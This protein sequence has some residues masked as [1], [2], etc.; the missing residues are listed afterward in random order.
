MII[1]ISANPAI[2]R[3]LQI[4]ELR[5]GEVNRALTVRPAPGGK[6]AHVAMAARALGTE[7]LWVGFLGGETGI[8]CARGLAALGIAVE[9]VHTRSPTRVNQEILDADGRITEILEPGGLVEED[10][11]CNMLSVCDRLFDFY[12]TQAQVVLT[13]SLPPGPAPIFY[14][15]LIE[16]AHACG[17]FV[18]LDT[19]GEA[20]IASLS[21]SPDLIKPNRAEAETALGQAISDETSTLEAARAFI[22]RGAKSVAL[23]LGSEGL[24]WLSSPECEPLILRAP[25]VTGRSTVGCGDATLAGFAVAIHRQEGLRERATLAV[26]C[27]AANCLADSPG[28][29]DA[30]LVS[31]LASLIKVESLAN[32]YPIKPSSKS[33]GGTT[34]K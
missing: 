4:K 16:A 12:K 3:R 24:L 14:A 11:I 25:V 21:S 23:S 17:C 8:E 7:V 13:G 5:V 2:D 9:V 33:T 10:E 1:C 6:A 31:R 26:A 32:H 20:L 29:I 15:R 30:Q 18:L 34:Q 28:M 19:G 22:E 27:G